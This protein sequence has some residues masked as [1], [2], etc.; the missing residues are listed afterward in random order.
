MEDFFSFSD[1]VI[2]KSGSGF[3]K[4]L[5]GVCGGVEVCLETGAY[6]IR[7]KSNRSFSA[8]NFSLTNFLLDS[9]KNRSVCLCRS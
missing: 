3:A 6:R 7:L 1:I 2:N 4:P 9:V 8:S 5:V